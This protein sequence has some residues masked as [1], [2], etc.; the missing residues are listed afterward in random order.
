M[1]SSGIYENFSVA[2]IMKKLLVLAY[3]RIVALCK[4][5]L[6]PTECPVRHVII[7][8]RKTSEEWMGNTISPFNKVFVLTMKEYLLY[9]ESLKRNAIKLA[10][11]Q[12]QR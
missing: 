3:Y 5:L 7:S 11:L 4:Q 9:N 1:V 6:V 2:H 10:Q 8:T 12:L